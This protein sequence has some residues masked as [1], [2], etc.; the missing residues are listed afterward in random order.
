M[1]ELRFEPIAEEHV[2]IVEEWLEDRESQRRVGGMIPF[3]PCFEYQQATPGY[4]EWIVYDGKTPVGLTGFQ[5]EDAGMAA[6]VLLVNPRLRSRGYGKTILKKL[7]SRPEAALVS[8]L[9]APIEPDNPESMRCFETAG[10]LNQ[11]K[12]PEN[13]EFLRYVYRRNRGL[14][15]NCVER[16]Q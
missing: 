14:L 8:E 9:Y 1:S 12:D 5:V 4:Y 10:F 6:V 3:R 13:S 11:G 16:T 15:N 7:C 2:A